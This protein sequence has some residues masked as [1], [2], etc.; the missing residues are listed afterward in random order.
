MKKLRK[1][2]ILLLAVGLVWGCSDDPKETDSIFGSFYNY[3][4]GRVNPNGL[5]TINNTIA[6]EVLLFEGSVDP[7]KYIGTVSSLGSVKI[8]FPEEKFYTI[9]AVQKS[10]YIE[11]LAQ[12]AQFNSLTYYSNTQP[13]TIPVS[14]SSTW[15]GGNWVFN[16][17]T[18]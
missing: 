10:N 4:T 8:R 17:N 16:N 6:S 11:R 9:I 12:A 13:Y 18:R 7:E 15:G 5:L 2:W 14:P 1:I 3:P